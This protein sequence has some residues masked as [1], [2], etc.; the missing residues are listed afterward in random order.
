MMNLK[1]IDN[2]FEIIEIENKFASAK[3]ALQG[4]HIYH[5]QAKGSSP[6]LWLSSANEFVMGKAIRGGVPICW[7]WFGMNKDDE[8]LPQHGFARTSLFSLHSALELEDGRDRVVL[9][10][11]DSKES[12]ALWNYKF[13]LFIEF[14]IGASLE[15]RLI[16]NNMDEEAFE[17]TQ[18]LHTYFE[19][20]NIEDVIITGLEERPYFD[21][22]T[23]EKMQQKGVIR[24][25][26]EVDRVYQDANKKIVLKDASHS[27]EIKNSGSNS[28]VVWNPWVEKSKR[29]SM[30][31]D[32]A[33]KTMVCIETANALD[34][35]KSVRAAEHYILG[36]Q[37]FSP[38]IKVF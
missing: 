37:L 34:D 1:I 27:V 22:L 15:I 16:T 20:S 9:R 8:N 21:A 14:D 17:I 2:N 24:F 33:Y 32:D 11:G 26:K 36:V 4:G 5:Y 12:R 28:V 10:L 35:V 3:I 19:V 38:L 13:E 29:M 30:M 6:L 31:N 25:N 18:A 7:P 23:Q